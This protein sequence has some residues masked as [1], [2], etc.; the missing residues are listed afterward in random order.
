MAQFYDIKR[1]SENGTLVLPLSQSKLH[2]Q[3]SPEAI[4]TFLKRFS[5]KI[6][7][8]SVDVV[9]LYT[10]SLY[11]NSDEVSYELRTKTTNQMV[12]HRMELSKMVREKRE[13]VPQ[14]IQFLPWDYVILNSD[15]YFEFLSLLNRA[16]DLDPWFKQAIE[17][18]LRDRGNT[19]ANVRFVIEELVV[20]HLIRQNYI[21]FPRTLS[22]E[23]GWKLIAY[24]GDYL[25]SDLYA[26][27]KGLLPINVLNPNKKEY[28]RSL[29]N[30]SANHLVDLKTASTRLSSGEGAKVVNK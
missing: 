3:Q 13:F 15:R 21:S 22:T 24:P 11:F 30:Y 26:Y 14:A 16:Y 1:I 2:G 19:E 10:N 4:Y 9:I 7:T 12:R 8:L 28:S 5:E 18:D 20:T 27:E 25:Q 23:M 6:H 17:K 29:Y